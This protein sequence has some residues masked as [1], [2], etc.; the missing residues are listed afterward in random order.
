MSRLLLR[1]CFGLLVTTFLWT[2]SAPGEGPESA[3]NKPLFNGQDLRG[4]KPVGGGQWEVVDG[5]LVGKSPKSE[6]RHGLL[7]SEQSYGDFTARIVFRI[8]AGNSGFYF[9][10]KPVEQAVGIHGV[11][12][13]LE[14]SDLVGG[15]YET[16]GRAWIAKPLNYLES[17]P[18]ERRGKRNKQWQQVVAGLDGEQWTTMVVSVHGDRIVTHVGDIL[19]CDLSDEKGAKEGVFAL[20]LHGN[21]DMHVEIKSVELLSKQTE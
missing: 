8:R 6:K 12:A 18:P 1:C 14:N 2:A 5:I 17:F 16:G 9:H 15:L 20:Q 19:A 11:Q 4:W 7:L 10:S 13:E 21:Q 3:E